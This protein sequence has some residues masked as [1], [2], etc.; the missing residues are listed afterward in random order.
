MEQGGDV[1][2]HNSTQQIFLGVYTL[3][4]FLHLY[5]YIDTIYKMKHIYIYVL[6]MLQLV[7]GPL[8]ICV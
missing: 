5:I 2:Q 3:I 8:C 6:F 4:Y 1:E 7:T